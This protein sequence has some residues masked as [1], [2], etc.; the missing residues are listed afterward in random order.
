M[1][2]MDDIGQGFNYRERETLPTDGYGY[3][4]IMINIA[5]KSMHVY[6]EKMPR[7]GGGQQGI[8]GRGTCWNWNVS[9]DR[10]QGALLSKSKVS[11]YA[12]SA[13]CESG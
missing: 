4:D 5:I 13:L 12:K 8:W 10:L 11:D 9:T 7:Q 1:D 3:E 2:I 6:K